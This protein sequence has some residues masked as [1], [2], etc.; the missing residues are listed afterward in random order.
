MPSQR[1][2]GSQLPFGADND[3]TQ[4]LRSR[5]IYIDYISKDLRTVIACLNGGGS[6][7]SCTSGDVILDQ[8]GSSDVLELVPFFDVQNTFLAR[9]GETPANTP[10]DTTNDPLADNNTHS[11][12]V[13]SRD[14]TAQSSVVSVV[15]H[16]GNLGFTDTVAIDPLYGTH[17]KTAT[18]TVQSLDDGGGG[19]TT[20]PVTGISIS[21]SFFESVP[22]NPNFVITESGDVNC[23]QTGA[24]YECVVDNAAASATIVLSGYGK[25][26]TDRVACGDGLTILSQTTSGAS[27]TT[28]FQLFGLAAGTTYN[29]TV[30]TGTSCGS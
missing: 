29:I 28:T 25:R 26:N 27:A 6:T 4:Q 1:P 7:E 11:R 3:P 18:L 13:I 9:W 17:E 10:V 5:G 22:G 19:G 12:G 8:S 20:P 16:R 30:S 15:A 24:A 14:V 23:N 2:S 21:G